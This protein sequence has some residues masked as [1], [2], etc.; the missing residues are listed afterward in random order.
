ML[1]YIIPKNKKE[2]EEEEEIYSY[3][4][5][6]KLSVDIYGWVRTFSL[7]GSENVTITNMIYN[8]SGWTPIAAFLTAG[9]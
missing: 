3:G 2:E 7:Y 5:I 9:A 1:I 4:M 6:G 8:L